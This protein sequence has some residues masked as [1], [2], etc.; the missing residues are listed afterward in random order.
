[1][2]G[3]AYQV[4]FSR[5]PLSPVDLRLILLGV[6]DFEVDT[7]IG[8][9]WMNS[10]I[11]VTPI[12][13]SRAAEGVNLGKSVRRANRDPVYILASACDLLPQ[14]HPNSFFR[15]DPTSTGEIE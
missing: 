8:R 14:R 5:V 10:D 2:P 4:R 12:I 13:Q 7:G 11:A 15:F 6:G 9:H 3:G 1:M